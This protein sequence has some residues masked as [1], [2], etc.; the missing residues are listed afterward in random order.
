MALVPANVASRRLRNHCIFSAIVPFD[1]CITYRS[2]CSPDASL[3]DG[4]FICDYHLRL[5]FKIAKMVLPIFD[6]ADSQFKRTLGRHLVGH[7]DKGAQRILI[8]TAENYETIFNLAGMM[9]SEQLIFH[10]IYNNTQQV[11]AICNLLKTSEN[12]MD[13]TYNVIENVYSSTRN[14]LALTDPNA[15]CSRVSR[16]DLR[17]FD[18]NNA[19]NAAGGSTG[20][21]IFG[22]F[23]GYL[24][25][26]IRRA[27]A[28]EILQIDTEELRLR[29]CPTCVISN[30]GLVASV[31][32]T[33]LYNPIRTNDVIRH[34]PNRLQVRNV[35]K[36]EGDTQKLERT[37]SKYEE[38]PIY[39]PLFLGYQLINSEN[40]ILRTNNFIPAVQVNYAPT[41]AAPFTPGIGLGQV[42]IAA[43]APGAV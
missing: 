12:Y 39:V 16:D 23:P 20:D 1:S 37:L 24:Q 8:P 10:L 26:L 2:P 17:Y 4:W 14:I 41:A 21:V 3:D 28:P 5:R 11:N 31:E 6:E 36:F 42:G 19:R 25:N 22:R 18:V 9:Q 40:N 27:V 13:N 32:G 43:P 33:E 15:Y 30:E 35:L 34:Q 38:Y 7:K 29:N